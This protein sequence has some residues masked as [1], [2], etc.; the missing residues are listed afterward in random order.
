MSNKRLKNIFLSSIHQDAG[1]TTISLGLYTV[2]K[3]RKLKTAFMKP[4]GQQFVNVGD[5]NIDKDSYRSEEHTSELQ[6]QR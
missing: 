1:K 4:V 2:F 3:E 5:L 6:S